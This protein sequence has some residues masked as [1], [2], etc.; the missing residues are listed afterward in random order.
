[1]LRNSSLDRV[2]T[3]DEILDIEKSPTIKP[4]PLSPRVYDGEPLSGSHLSD[5]SHSGLPSGNQLD[6]DNIGSFGNQLRIASDPWQVD[7]LD[8]D[9]VSMPN[10]DYC[11][12]PKQPAYNS[13]EKERHPFEVPNSLFE[14]DPM[15]LRRRALRLANLRVISL[16]TPI[17]YF[18]H[19]IRSTP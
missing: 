4:F 10:V 2:L 18:G 7:S 11:I 6:S 1:M 3:L 8:T 16:L 9:Q 17:L 19:A 14:G 13:G 5:F 15:A 12:Q